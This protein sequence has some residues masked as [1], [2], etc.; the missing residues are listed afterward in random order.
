MAVCPWSV[1]IFSVYIMC[2]SDSL[3]TCALYD[4][5]PEVIFQKNEGQVCVTGWDLIRAVVLTEKGLLYYTLNL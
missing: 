2:V 1:S 5:P 4:F 3:P